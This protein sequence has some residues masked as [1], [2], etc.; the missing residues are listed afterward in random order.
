M[1]RELRDGNTYRAYADQY[2]ELNRQVVRWTEQLRPYGPANFQFRLVGGRA[3]IFEINARFSGTTGLRYHAGFNSVEMTLR[4]VLLGERVVQPRI[5]PVVILRHW[6]ETVLTPE[7]L[8][9]KDS[10]SACENG[11]RAGRFDVLRTAGG[12]IQGRS[13]AFREDAPAPSMAALDESS[14][15]ENG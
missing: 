7:A 8:L 11:E 9:S 15:V 3:K 14:A 2:P 6:E 4:R 1:R 12:G 10:R 13:R 5:K